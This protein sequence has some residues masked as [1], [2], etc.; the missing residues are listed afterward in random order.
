MRLRAKVLDVEAGLNV[1]V[2]D[3]DD[4]KQL[5]VSV[6][7]R[8]K[9]KLGRNE[10]VALV[11]MAR[12]GVQKEVLLFSDAALK[13]S[14]KDGDLV[15]V[16]ATKRPESL[17][18]VRKKL[19]GGVLLDSEVKAIVS[20]LMREEL[21][22]AELAAFISAVYTRGMNIDE[23]TSLTNAI[24]E[25]GDRLEFDGLVVS[26]H[27]IGGV[28]AD[29]VSMLIVPIIA[30]LGIKIPK[31]CTRAISSAAGTADSM[32]VLCPVSLSLQKIKEVVRK[33]NGC[34]AWGGA[35]SMAVADDKLIKIRNP[36][37]LDPQELLL[38]SILAKKKAEG[39]RMV[40]LDIPTGR[41]TKILEVDKARELARNFQSLGTN[42]GLKVDCII[43]D[44]SEP[45]MPFIGPALEARGVIEAFQ[46]KS[47][48]LLVEKACLLSGVL[49]HMARG[50]SKEEGYRLARYQ[51]SSGK[52][53]QKF[54]EIIAEQGGN[55]DVSPEDIEVGKFSAVVSA[56]SD[57][58]VNHIDSHAISRVCR[59]AGAPLD[60]RA[61]M[62]L[63]VVVG[64]QVR[65]GEALF[66]VFSS[67]KEK[68]DY[69]LE[70]AGKAR[71][72]ELE[73]I[74]LDVI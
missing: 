17:D 57:G 61:G 19:D 24:Y 25:S 54:K 32:E 30:S 70:T 36:L 33:T 69:A 56:S 14:A 58:K 3:D 47:N 72:V 31:T 44:G 55:P 5:D 13:L 34:I 63:K 45:T 46:G 50:V 18:F 22:V 40:L 1:I 67:S 10:C 71:V 41:G 52:A 37:R 42:L 66:E 21:S 11:D 27:S 23:V 4:M 65:E 74:I 68:L 60:K 29:R 39:A 6:G 15:E 48:G 16:E 73:K 49:L 2:L 62:V 35:V 7:D 53:F 26:E 59:A 64:Q 12:K 38:S 20:D 43:S 28:A 8:V 9:V 51:L